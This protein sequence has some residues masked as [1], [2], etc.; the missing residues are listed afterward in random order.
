MESCLQAFVQDFRT[1]GLFWFLSF[2]IVFQILRILFG[3]VEKLSL[4]L[5]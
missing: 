3:L 1:L 2:T 5:L 4:L